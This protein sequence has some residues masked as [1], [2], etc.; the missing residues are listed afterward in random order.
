MDFSHLHKV[1]YNPAAKITLEQCRSFLND[2][3]NNSMHHSE[4][5]E[6]HDEFDSMR[7]YD[8]A[9]TAYS[10]AFELLGRV[11]TKKKEYCSRKLNRCPVCGDT[12]RGSIKPQKRF[13]NGRKTWFIQC[14]CGRKTRFAKSEAQVRQFWNQDKIVRQG[15][16]E[17]VSDDAEDADEEYFSLD[18]DLDDLVDVLEEDDV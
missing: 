17:C 1:L 11:D 16:W 6:V 10:I 9:S 4:E 2:L 12:S 5:C 8:G 15:F 3:H 7:Y 13:V 14:R 18:D